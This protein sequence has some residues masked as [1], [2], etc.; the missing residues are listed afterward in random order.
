[1]SSNYLYFFL[2]VDT[3]IYPL[4]QIVKTDP[5]LTPRTQ[6]TEEVKPDLRIVRPQNYP[7]K[8]R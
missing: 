4:E 8:K 6:P 1:M 7:E 2:D 5:T 3:N